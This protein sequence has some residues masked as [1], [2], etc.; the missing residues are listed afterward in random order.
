MSEAF[1]QPIAQQRRCQTYQ[2]PTAP[3]LKLQVPPSP[4]I[5]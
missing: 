3:H 2:E 5:R 1:P 4:V